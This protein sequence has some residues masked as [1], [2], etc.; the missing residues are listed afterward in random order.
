MFSLFFCLIETSVNIQHNQ[1]T[2]VFEINC[3]IMEKAFHSYNIIS[4]P[5]LCNVVVAV[6]KWQNRIAEARL[7]HLK[8]EE[9]FQSDLGQ[10][11]FKLV[12]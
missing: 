9:C 11:F 5:L 1:S 6:T 7:L 8:L 12:K 10:L 3:S 2:T 4:F